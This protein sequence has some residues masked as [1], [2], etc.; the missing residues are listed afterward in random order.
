MIDLQFVTGDVDA[1]EE[2]I[3]I[4]G[5]VGNDGFAGSQSAGYDVVLLVIAAHQKE[6]LGLKGIATAV[7][8]KIAQ[9]GIFFK[10]FQK[11]FGIK[12]RLEQARQGS[13][14]DPITP[15]IAKYIKTTPR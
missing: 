3:F 2:G 11:D 8:V 5:V 7:T 4:K 13:F 1:G 15:S 10:D 9:K 12:S 6:Y 14:A